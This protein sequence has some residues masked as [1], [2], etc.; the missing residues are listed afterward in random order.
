MNIDFYAFLVVVCICITIYE[1]SKLKKTT[2][3]KETAPPNNHTHP[4]HKFRSYDERIASINERIKNLE[5]II[6]PD[7]D[8]E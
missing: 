5:I 1:L 3:T 6:T 7:H 4:L 8:E 2:Q